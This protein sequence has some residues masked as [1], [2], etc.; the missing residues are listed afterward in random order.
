VTAAASIHPAPRLDVRW[1]G[2]VLALAALYFLTA[3]LG[4]LMAIPG[5]YVTPVWPPSGIALAAVLLRG[6]RVWPGIWLGSFAANFWHFYDIPMGLATGVA[7]PATMAIGACLAALLGRELLRRFADGRNSL[8]RVLDVCAFMA[9]GGV[10]SCLVSATIG[11]TTL[12][13][14]GYTAWPDYG[15]AW[16]TW[17]LGDTGGVF[18]VS[19]LLLVWG[20]AHQRKLAGRWAE[21]FGGFGL[22]IAVTYYVFCKNTAVLF[23]GK[24]LTFIIL[25]PFL[26]WAAV[27][28]GRRGAAGSAGLITLLALWGTIHETGPFNLGPRNEALLLLELFLGVMA[29]TALCLAAMFT[30]REHLSAEQQRAV[31]ELESHVRERTSA[32]VQSEAQARQHLA[33]AERARAALLSILEDQREVEEKLRESQTRTQ[34]LVKSSNIGLWDWNLVTNDVFFSPEWKSQLG[35]TGDEVPG[36]YEEW[37][38]RLHPEDRASSLRAVQDFREGRRADYD[39]EFRMRHKDGSWRSILT[40]ADLIRDASGKPVRM[41]G[42][43]IDITARKQAEEKLRES[44]TRFRELAENIDE[45]FWIWTATPENPQLLYVSPAYAT[46][47]GR[48]CESLYG[49]PQSWKEAL[50]PDDKKWVLAEIAH[51]DFEK[52]NDLSYRIVRPDQSIRWIRDRIFPVRD[53][54]GVV[55]RFAGIAED[56][57]ESKKNANALERAEKQYHSI[58][59]DAI[60]GIFRTSLDGKFLVANPA[61]ARIFGFDSPEQLIAERGDIAQQGYV[62]PRRREEFKRVMQE[63]G[64]VNSFEYEAYRKD[65][66]RGWICENARAVKSPSG[67]VLYFEGIFED[68]TERKRAEKALR[69]S[70]ERFRTIFEQAPLG[71][72]EGEIATERFLSANQR[73]IDILGYSLD[74]LRELTFRDY[75]HPED[76]QKDLLEFQKLASGEI[77]TYAMEKRYL[78]KDGAIIWVNLTVTGLARPGEKPL[79]CIAVIDDITDRIKAEEA[80]SAQALRYKTLM[81]TSTDSIYVLDEKGD[82]QDANAA[83]LVRRGYT[84]PEVKG[85]NVADWDA[86]WNPER[87][88]ERL[89]KLRESSAVFETRHLC[90]DGSL[91]DVEVCATGVRIAEEQLFFCVTRDITERKQA[92]DRLRRSE[93]KFKALFDLAPVGISVLD[94]QHNV[95]EANPALE[96]MTR[97]RREEL[98]NG[99]HRD[100]RI[101]NADGTPMLP[102]EIPSERAMAENRPINDVEAGFVTENGEIIWS[103]VSAAPLDLP[104]GSAV[105]I[106]QDITERKRAAEALEV[107]NRQL[108]ILSRQLFHIQEEERRHLARELHDEIG[109]TLTAAKINLKIIAPDVPAKITGRLDD[110]IQLLDQLLRQVRQLSLD[111]RPPLLDELGLV[112]T[113]RWLVDQQAQRAGLRVTFTANVNGLELDP[114]VQTTCFRIAQEAITNVIRHSGAKNVAVVLRHEAERLTLNVRDDGAGFDPAVIQQRTAQH[115][116]LGLVSMKER[117]LLVRGGFEI[118]SAPGQG[119]EIRAWFPLPNDEHPS[120]AETA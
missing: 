27:R 42:C 14:A 79:T 49:S 39:V 33:G 43:H 6:R 64:V 44:E 69:E 116:T 102:H 7:T 109:Q 12:C 25:I 66:S 46:I 120:T 4:L 15:Q 108:R 20:G 93:Q 37:E 86:Q 19:P 88:R 76:L 18:I 104:D 40:H 119:A 111:L 63:Q 9:L 56:I 75:S 35:C 22:M 50:H 90:K 30:E 34:L 71:I 59:N 17:W 68:V 13:L 3:R 57:T 114:D 54:A 72:S 53:R 117:A 80:L 92:E 81:E 73:Y 101:L 97:M 21:L 91:F 10:A 61:A 41:M 8:E 110:S 103:Q 99:T 28:F 113:L 31:E 65:G 70:E 55:V 51:L 96:Q 83:F 2:E 106:T 45:V 58:F 87:L 36:R 52:V 23:T 115:S 82:L 89:R 1:L 107:A 105:V 11:V 38:N 84:V 95:I 67:E 62:D 29:L 47:W 16:L 24:P 26:V 77:R 48:S 74:E 94:R 85:L 5:A 118:H 32:L 100:R 60:E 98:L 78:R 112:P